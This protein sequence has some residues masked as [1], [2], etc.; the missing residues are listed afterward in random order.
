MNTNQRVGVYTC[1][2]AYSHNLEGEYSRIKQ[3]TNI[4]IGRIMG[5]SVIQRKD[6]CAMTA[7]RPLFRAR[8]RLAGTPVSVKGRA[9]VRAAVACVPVSN[10]AARRHARRH[11]VARQAGARASAAPA[12]PKYHAT[13]IV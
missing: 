13:Q 4:I 11:A 2:K 8:T 1:H 9:G 5:G 7:F 3:H 6:T 12:A 10:A